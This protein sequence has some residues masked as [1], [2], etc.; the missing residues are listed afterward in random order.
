MSAATSTR[1]GSN[2][3]STATAATTS[4]RYAERPTARV[5]FYAA[6]APR[7]WPFQLVSL[8]NRRLPPAREPGFYRI[9]VDNGMWSFY[10]SG[11]RPSLDKWY[12]KLLVF[13]HDAERLR[14]PAEVWVVLPDW[15]HDFDF[16]YSAAKHSLAKR[17][18]KDYRCLVVVHTSS[19]FLW[20][21]G[22]PYGYAAD[23]YASL[24]HVHGLAAPLKLPC[25]RYDKRA[26][27][28]IVDR[29]GLECQLNIVR[30]VCG[31]AR[32][33]GLVC[34]GLGLVLEPQHVRRAVGL[35]L[36]SFDSTA[37]T[38]PNKRSVEAILGRQRISLGLVGAK[39]LKE[40]ELFLLV[41]LRSLL[42]AGVELELDAALKAYSRDL[43]LGIE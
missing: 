43:P 42:E 40:K 39:T 16:T 7:W 17:L 20:A 6:Q 1:T 14:K 8:A 36:D 32:S 18:C 4:T 15:L 21:P 12:H 37:W 5:R 35:G 24:D 30:Q 11:G 28:H 3:S 10:R 9:L 41:K 13:A 25:L 27:R 34:H 23:L 19:R 26:R 38:R 22:G 2:A 33:K 31:T 29:R